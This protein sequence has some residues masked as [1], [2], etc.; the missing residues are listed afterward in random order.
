LKE[1]QIHENEIL[2]GDS[3]HKKENV[4]K[5]LFLRKQYRESKKDNINLLLTQNI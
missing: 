2:I 3:Q 4:F 1:K 5:F